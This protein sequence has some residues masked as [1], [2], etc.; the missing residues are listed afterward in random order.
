MTQK[1]IP[2]CRQHRR[3][4]RKLRGSVWLTDRDTDGCGMR[5]EKAHPSLKFEG[6][7]IKSLF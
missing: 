3:L 6:S 7:G 1:L 5:Q 2:D 4:R